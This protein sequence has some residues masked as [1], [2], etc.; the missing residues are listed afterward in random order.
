MAVYAIGDLQGCHD[1]LRRLLD[2]LR[3]EPAHDRL[4]FVGDL[5]NRGPQSLETLRFIRA[6]GEAAQTVLGNHDIHLLALAAGVGKP[7][8]GDTLDAVLQAPDRDELLNWLRRRPLLIHDEPLDYIIV[9]AGLA[10]QWDLATAKGCAAEVQAALQAD[11]THALFTQLY[12]NQPDRW[13]EQLSG[14]ARL[15]FSINAL[16]RMRYCS[17]DGR[18]DFN[19]KGKPGTQPSNLVP[20]FEVPG[21]A[22][23]DVNIV[24]GHWSTLGEVHVPGIYGID[25]GCVWGNCLS[26]LELSPGT[27]Q[28]RL[29]TQPCDSSL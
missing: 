24:F 4:Y 27:G 11:D 5:V 1:P 28:P 29:I 18:L 19:A 3:F 8:A 23:R 20:W 21:R 25:T 22:N 7:K 16:T 6:L 26:A 14:M 2:R 9:H 15:R 17:R 12:G 13:R 10:P